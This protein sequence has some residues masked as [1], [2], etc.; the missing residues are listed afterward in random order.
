MV[1]LPLFQ[2]SASRPDSPGL[3]FGGGLAQFLV[4]AGLFA[5]RLDVIDEPVENVADGGLAGFQAVVT[6]E[7]AAVDDAA[8]AGNVRQFLADAARSW[9]RRCWCR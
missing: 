3:Q 8:Q 5:E 6:G 4:R 7:D 1:R 2:S 9:C